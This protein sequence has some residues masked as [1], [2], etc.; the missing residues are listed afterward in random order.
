MQADIIVTLLPSNAHIGD[1]IGA[2]TTAT[3]GTILPKIRNWI[4]FIQQCQS[5]AQI[6]CMAFALIIVWKYFWKTNS[7]MNNY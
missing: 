1:D 6:G 5:V 2:A 3:K 7:H 4:F